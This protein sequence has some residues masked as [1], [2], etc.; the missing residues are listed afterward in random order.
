MSVEHLISL[1]NSV[2]S[3]FRTQSASGRQEQILGFHV[4]PSHKIRTG[5][6]VNF[7]S[8]PLWGQ[9]K[10]VVGSTSHIETALFAIIWEIETFVLVTPCA[11]DYYALISNLEEAL[12]DHQ[13][14]RVPAET[15]S[16]D[17]SGPD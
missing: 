7:I 13:V 2:S 9:R 8:T 6:E 15:S 12:A 10:I 3:Q 5:L 11:S 4:G 17:N 14:Y 16:S 1:L